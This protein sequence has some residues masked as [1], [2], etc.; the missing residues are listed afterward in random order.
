MDFKEYEVFV[1]ENYVKRKSVLPEKNA[2]LSSSTE[3]FVVSNFPGGTLVKNFDISA[4]AFISR[5]GVF[6]LHFLP[7]VYSLSALV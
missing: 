6:L 7:L 5:L 2:T 4:L 3:N 1:R